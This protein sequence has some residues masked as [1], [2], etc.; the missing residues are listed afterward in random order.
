[1]SGLSWL[2]YGSQV[3]GN[4][5]IAAS[6]GAS[7]AGVASAVTLSGTVV[8]TMDN[9]Y[10]DVQPKW[11]A[12]F[13][14]SLAVLVVC[15]VIAIV[16]PSKDTLLIIAASEVGETVLASKEAQAIG[17]EVGALA[18]DSLKLLRKYVSEQLG[19]GASE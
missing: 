15:S 1:M 14:R 4:L 10:E 2:L 17:G 13:G 11:R 3:A 5:G 9:D 7:L 6:I 12:A 16:T 8:S 18:S 19:E